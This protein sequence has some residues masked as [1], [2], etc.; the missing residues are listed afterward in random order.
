MS[1]TDQTV[2][3][4]LEKSSRTIPFWAVVAL[5]IPLPLLGELLSIG[6]KSLAE[7][8]YLF[9]LGY[10]VFADEKIIEKAEKY[11]LILFGTGV[12][13]SILNVYLFIWSDGEYEV[14]NNITDC[15]SEWIMIIAL[16]G[17]AKRYLNFSGKVSDYM[18]TRSFLYYI[19]H[20]VW[21][22]VFQYVLYAIFGNNTLVLFAG[23]LLLAAIATFACCEIS[24]RIPFL[25]FLTGTKS[26]S[27]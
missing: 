19:Y 8:M 5:G 10:F 21:V 22:V 16:I 3:K 6:G 14:L 12:A 17:M 26:R 20:F 1:R 9:L 11:R 25:C 4:E 15:V 2:K 27:K 13:A 24:I 18:K 23:T 7:F